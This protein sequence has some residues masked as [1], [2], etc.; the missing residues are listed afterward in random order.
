MSAKKKPAPKRG[1]SR[2]QAPAKKPVPGWVWM[3][4]GLV[5]GGF[6]A[7]LMQLEPGRK[8]IQRETA[9]SKKTASERPQPSTPTTTPQPVKPKYDFYTL[10][11]ESQ[12]EVPAGAIP[13][14][15]KPSTTPVPL[16]PEQ[17]AERA[18]ALLEGREPPKI[19]PPVATPEADKAATDK[20]AA[21]AEAAKAVPST[22][23]FLQAGSFRNQSDADKL[24]AQIILLGQNVQIESGKVREETWHRVLVGPYGSREQLAAAQKQLAGNGFSNLLLQQRQSR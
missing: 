13:E 10:L 1:A 24:R 11:P 5:I 7:F 3:V 19:T 9:E 20:A 22:Q 6:I 18:L 12:V 4:C 21:P 14:E 2:Y 15:Q 23:F 8:D 17:E 16:T